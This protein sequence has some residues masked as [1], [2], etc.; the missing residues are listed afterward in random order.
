MPKVDE[1]LRSE[2]EVRETIKKAKEEKIR[3]IRESTRNHDY[4][5]EVSAS[6]RQ[7][8]NQVNDSVK[9]LSNA[10]KIEY[11]QRTPAI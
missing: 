2:I 10:A 11:R 4:L 3:A 9:S 8:K 7:N 1:D 6:K 5:R